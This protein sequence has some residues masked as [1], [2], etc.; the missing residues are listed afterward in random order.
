MNLELLSY[1][2]DVLI[3][4]FLAVMIFYAFRLT[5]SLN[6]FRRNRNQF[7]EVITKLVTSINQAEQSIRDLKE[8]SAEEAA[9]LN[10]LV[11]QAK[12]LSTELKDIN[13]VSETMAERLEKLASE[14]RKILRGD[15]PQEEQGDIIPDDSDL[16]SFMIQDKYAEPAK[17]EVASHQ[18][19]E[20]HR[21]FSDDMPEDL[22]SEAEKELFR[23]LQGTKR[24]SAGR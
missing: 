15:T 18:E 3:L 12:S 16:P 1:G 9:T 11:R 13:Q 10:G 14:N 23:A 21:E 7:D 8:V 4:I 19:I 17:E 5:N 2:L 6:E 22:Q 20:E 24:K